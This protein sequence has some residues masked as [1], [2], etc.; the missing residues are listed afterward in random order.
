[1]IALV[2]DTILQTIDCVYVKLPGGNS[3]FADLKASQR[4]P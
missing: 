4:E 2:L 1:M 3:P